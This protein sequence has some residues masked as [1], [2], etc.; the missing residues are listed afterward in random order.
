MFDDKF[1]AAQLKLLRLL[2]PIM[3][4]EEVINGSMKENFNLIASS[5]SIFHLNHSLLILLKFI[6]D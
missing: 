2:I 1:P 3:G 5:T 6:H 4:E